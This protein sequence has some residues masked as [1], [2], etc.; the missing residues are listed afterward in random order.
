MIFETF[1]WVKV[2]FPFLKTFFGNKGTPYLLLIWFKVLKFVVRFCKKQCVA[3]K[4]EKDARVFD[5]FFQLI[6]ELITW[7]LV[8]LTIYWSKHFLFSKGFNK[9]VS[10]NFGKFLPKFPGNMRKA[11]STK[12]VSIIFL[13][14]FIVI[15]TSMYVLTYLWF[16]TRTSFDTQLA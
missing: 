2:F 4:N 5:Y 13:N 1:F 7:H 11:A 12:Y 15:R 9:F 14:T 6:P 3:H 16:R 8:F 10:H